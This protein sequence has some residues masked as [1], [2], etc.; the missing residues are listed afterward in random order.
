MDDRMDG[1]GGDGVEGCGNQW[2]WWVIASTAQLGLGI[3]SFRRG[4]AG[5]SRLMPF[6]AFAVASLFVGSAASATI[7]S[8]QACGMRQVEDYVELGANIKSWIRA[9][10]GA[11]KE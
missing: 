4:Y 11:Q 6:K 2:C 10:A 1:G 5:D 9:S 7:A 8:L 3:S